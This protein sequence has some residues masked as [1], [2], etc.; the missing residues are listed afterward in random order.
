MPR[1][2]VVQG[3]CCGP[4]VLMLKWAYKDSELWAHTRRLWDLLGIL[5]L[6]SWASAPFA[7][8]DLGTLV[9]REIKGQALAGAPA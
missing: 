9:Q 5:G 6:A 4:L 2:V 8:E 7:K 1:E 3:I